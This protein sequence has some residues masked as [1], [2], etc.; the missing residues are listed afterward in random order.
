MLDGQN[1]QHY[2][3]LMDYMTLLMH[4]QVEFLDLVNE[5]TFA[6]IPDDSTTDVK[7]F[8]EVKKKCKMMFCILLQGRSLRNRHNQAKPKKNHRPNQKS[9]KDQKEIRSSTT[10]T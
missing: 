4:I 2:L 1:T 9:A 8:K 6:S 3:D 5:I 10:K 7:F